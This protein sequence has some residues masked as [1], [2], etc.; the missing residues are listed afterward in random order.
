METYIV[1]AIIIVTSIISLTLLFYTTFMT[2]RAFS[3]VMSLFINVLIS[4]ILFLM[5]RRFPFVT[6]AWRLDILVPSAYF[7]VGLFF[8]LKRHMEFVKTAKMT[9]EEFVLQMNQ[10]Y[11]IPAEYVRHVYDYLEMQLQMTRWNVF[12]P[13]MTFVQ[14]S[15]L[16]RVDDWCVWTEILDNLPQGFHLEKIGA[17]GECSNP[18]ELSDDKR[19]DNAYE[20]L[21]LGEY[22][23]ILYRHGVYDDLL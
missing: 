2:S 11:D 23:D 16:S 18:E 22:F 21:T 12:V 10:R 1:K 9:R 20:K 14:L 17:A 4:C 8:A 5:L 19:L 15:R 6:F 13:D 3:L 7:A